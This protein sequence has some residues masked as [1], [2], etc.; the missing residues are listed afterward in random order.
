MLNR[1]SVL[2]LVIGCIAGFLGAGP[3][4]VA[5]E[6]SGLPF[7]VGDTVTLGFDQDASQPSF[8]R[9]ITCT[10]TE[11]RGVYVKCGRQSRIARGAEPER[12]LSMRYVVEITR[13][14]N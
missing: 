5:Q 14:E 6:G 8:G 1:W 2:L 9:E 4:V 11:I 13:K 10:I 12:W 7:V 3:A